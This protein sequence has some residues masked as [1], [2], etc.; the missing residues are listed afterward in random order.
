MEAQNM[1]KRNMITI[2]TMVILAL[3]ITGNASGNEITFVLGTD[4]NHAS[5][6][7]ASENAAI[8]I[9]IYNATQANILNFSNESVL[10][11]SSLDNDM[12]SWINTTVNQSTS[13][14]TYNLSTTIEI[15]NVDDVNITK[16]WIY[17]GDENIENLIAY[18]DNKFYGNATAVDQPKPPE[19]RPKI[20]FVHSQPY[21]ITLVNQVANDP[22][23]SDMMNVTTYFGRSNVDVSFNLSD[24]DVIFLCCLTPAV[25]EELT[26]TVNDAKNNSAD[27]IAISPSEQSFNLHNVNISDPEYSNITEYLEYPSKENFKRLITFVGVKFCNVS[28]EIL[29]PISRPVYGIYHPY[30]P[31][32]F[33]DTTDYMSWYD[34]AGRYDRSNPTVGIITGSYK[35][36]D[37]DSALLN[38]LIESF[39]SRNVNAIVSTYTYHDPH[40]MDYLM[41]DGEPVVDSLIIISRGSRLYYKN[42][43]KGIADL[44]KLNVTALNGVRLFYSMTPEEWE[45]GPH[46]IPPVQSYQVA[47]AELDGIIEPIVIC[48]K[49]IDPITEVEYNR[50]IDYQIDWLTNRTISW[51]RLHRMNNS[52]KKI[53]IP[54]YSAG[55]GKAN[56]GSDID[57]YLDTQ[58]SLTNLLAA[59]ADRGYNLGSEPLPNKTELTDLMMHQGSNF[60]TWAPG[61][62]NERVEQG[63]VI[64]IPKSE[65]LKWFGEL[66]DDKQNE[67]VERWGPPPGKIM[68]WKND[69]DE[70]LVIPKIQFGNVLLAPDPT[71]GWLQNESVMYY[72]GS[73]PPTHQCLAFY[74]WL[75]KE[76]D[77]DAVFAIFTSIE[78]MPGKECG[79]SAHDWGAILLQDVPLIHVLPMDAEGIFDRR[80]ANMLIVDFM[81]P[82]IVPSG[83]YGNLSSLQQEISLYNQAVSEPVKEKYKNNIIAECRNLSL[84]RDLEVDLNITGSNATVFKEFVIRLGSYLQE[85]KTEY[86]PYGPHTLSEPP[87]GDSLVE[88]VEAMLGD[89][90]TNNVS[91][92]NSSEGLTTTLLSEVLL[93]GSNPDAAQSD[94]LGSV[95]DGVTS[96]LVLA[97]EYANRIDA[98]T[99]EIPR[100]LDA[101]EGKY[102]LPGSNGDPVRNPDALPTGRN[103]CTFDERLIPTKE[104]WEVGK[105]LTDQLLAQHISETGDYPRKIAFLLWSV[106]TSRH[107]GTMESEIFHLLGVKPVWDKR[108]RVKDVKL[109]NSSELGRPRIDVVVTTSG[110]YRDMYSGKIK[111]IDKAVRLA[112]QAND[113]AY[114]N[115]VN[116][117]SE[118]IYGTLMATGNYTSEDARNLSM[119]RI[120]SPHPDSYS[121]GLQNAIP[122][123]NTWNDT[124]RLANL[125]I[126][127]MSYVYGED[128]WGEHL[129]YLF[130][131][132]LD[133]VEVCVFSRSSNVYGV[134]DHPEV[135]AYFGGLSLA[136]ESIS[137]DT[138]DMYINNLRDANNP[139]VETLSHFLNR[140]LR[141]R[142]FNPKWIKGM[143]EHGYDGTRY[144]AQFTEDLWIW[145]VVTPDLVTD[146]MWKQTYDI[147][148]Q[149]PGMKD[150]FDSNNPYAQQ[151][152]TARMLEASQKL[153]AEGN[154][155]WNADPD[156]I[157]SLVKEYAESV[158]ENGATCCHHTCGNPLLD[159]FISGIISAPN[160]ELVSPDVAAKYRDTMDAAAGREGVSSQPT[161]TDTGSSSGGGGGDGTY[162]P[163]WFDDTDTEDTAQ[164]SRSSTSTM[165]ETV[166]EGG[167]G[168]EVSQPVESV[169]ESKPSEPSDYVEGQEMEVE[170]QEKSGGLSFSGAPM[171]GIILVIALMVIIYWGYRRRR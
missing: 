118:L 78:A 2:L 33:T 148:I 162:P 114:P 86:M 40:S 161:D 126:D 7:N 19:N 25:V 157:K 83:L 29:P 165:N 154:P 63:N 130:K 21:G 140:E 82:T 13:I 58:A 27:V 60:G 138:P 151:S 150:F 1:N 76:F 133:G 43:S 42:A 105:E 16:Y 167:V 52:D 98:C 36:M 6:V 158:A 99:V 51:M 117:S 32:I 11:L 152:I 61:A 127:R 112:A 49:A 147:Y 102:I 136:I 59:M 3:A 169:K 24:Q 134:L 77:A 28:A 62:L 129:N 81:T 79:L 108:G 23:I 171:L 122:A 70:Y 34:S 64:L 121:T 145:Q 142:Y 71:W 53:V 119:T 74:L 68:V 92:I 80:R 10:F 132:N 164:Q 123:S 144:M 103:L 8:D 168:T 39:E 135:A 170:K 106:E 84:D 89:E 46:G 107:Q 55:G 41:V 20:A 9:N 163:G 166:R 93:N 4:E 139:T 66:P 26:N 97:V 67:M 73:I 31:E 115:Y 57:Y 110:A 109:I 35:H 155:Y 120:F 128:V 143:M 87:V 149:D 146:D 95:S 153:D 125:Y 65:Y 141:T 48:G 104:A 85:L 94:L 18:M 5:L 159:K 44:Q 30:A 54:Y 38:A 96:D 69:T 75:N 137:G 156:V 101:L 91:A 90:F 124:D 45:A 47:F 88:L 113:T 37:R 15:G 72:N 116:E 12:V 111:L 22:F 50:P 14:I 131:E 17:G 100:I 56:V 160:S